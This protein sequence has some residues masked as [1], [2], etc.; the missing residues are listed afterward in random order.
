[1]KNFIESPL[2]YTVSKYKLLSQIIPHFDFT[3]NTFVDLFAGGGSVFINILDKYN[4]I[5][6]NEKIKDIIG[7]YYELIYNEN[8]IEQVI[9]NSP[10]NQKEFNLLRED[11]N[12]CPDSIKLWALMASSTNNMMRFNKLLKYNQTYGKR[13]FN[14]NTLKKTLLFKERLIKYQNKLNLIIGDFFDID[15]KNAHYYIDPPYC[16]ITLEDGSIGNKQISEAGYNAFWSKENEIKLY[17][18]ITDLKYKNS[19]FTLSGIYQKEDKFSWLIKKLCDNGYEMINIDCD[20]NK[21]S[22]KENKNIKE[23]LIKG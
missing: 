22:R 3:K 1:M 13:K 14:N 9:K 4:D 8:L 5:I 20:Y 2:N 23:I 10:E 6:V 16:Y 21:V 12:K 17:K 11:Y 15:I 19:T 7:I 18:F